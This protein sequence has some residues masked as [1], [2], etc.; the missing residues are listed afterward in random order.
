MWEC[1]CAGIL[2]QMFKNA[3]CTHL[4]RNSNMEPGHRQPSSLLSALH[5]LFALP[6]KHNAAEKDTLS[7]CMSQNFRNDRI[8]LWSVKCYN[9]LLNQFSNQQ[10]T[11]RMFLSRQEQTDPSL[12]MSSYVSFLN[13]HCVRFKEVAD[14]LCWVMQVCLNSTLMSIVSV[15]QLFATF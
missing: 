12:S 13:W 15:E 11:N 14:H 2:L 6:P 3:T 5:S 10:T 8:Y 4:D 7:Q 9:I 1:K